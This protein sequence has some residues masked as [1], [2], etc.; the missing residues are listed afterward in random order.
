[1]TKETKIGSKLNFTPKDF[2]EQL[3]LFVASSLTTQTSARMCAE[4]SIR[5][6]ED[7]GDLTYCQRFIDAMTQFDRTEPY[8][9]WLRAFSPV[10][11]EKGKLVKDK[12]EAILSRFPDNHDDPGF[13]L[14]G[15]LAKP[16][17]EFAP[18]KA[19]TLFTGQNVFDKIRSSLGSFRNGNSHTPQ[20]EEATL[21]IGLIEEA[22]NHAEARLSNSRATAARAQMHAVG[23]GQDN[24]PPATEP[25]IIEGEAE[26]I[27]ETG[28]EQ[29]EGAVPVA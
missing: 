13:D 5:H 28:T 23:N 19:P 21:V 8:V 11:M 27:Q 7:C 4:M 16:Y 1:M 12:S 15:A 10:T 20:D 3:D 14:A 25:H 22:V 2:D 24:N 18:K 26:E 6:F 17:W 29:E 9:K